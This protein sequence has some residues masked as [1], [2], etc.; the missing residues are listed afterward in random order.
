[1]S[2]YISNVQMNSVQTIIIIKRTKG[3][4]KDTKVRHSRSSTSTNAKGDKSRN[5]TTSIIYNKSLYYIIT[6]QTRS[7]YDFYGEFG[8]L[9]IEFANLISYRY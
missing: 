3:E 8:I 2:V 4:L 1:M 9:E 7:T 5:V 6:G